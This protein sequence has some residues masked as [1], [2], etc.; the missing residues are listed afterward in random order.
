ME[1]CTVD[2]FEE[3]GKNMTAVKIDEDVFIFD[4]G[5]YIPGIVELQEEDQK[6]EYTVQ[7]LRRVKA[8]PDDRVLD[9]LGWRDKVRAII[10]SH[11]HLDHVGGLPYL[12]E[13]YPNVPIYGTPFT[14]KFLELF[15][16]DEK[17]ESKN[18]MHVIKPDSTIILNGKSGSYKV[19]F[20]NTTHSTIQCV[21][22]ALH[23]RD[24]IF[25]YALDLK[26][27]NHPTMGRPPNYNKMRELGKKGVKVLVLDALYSSTEK[28]PGSETVAKH[29]LE[30]AFSRATDKKAAI[31]ITTFSSHVERLNN[32]VEFARKTKREIIFLGRSLAKYMEAATA[33]GMCPFKNHV[34]VVKYRKQINSFLSRIE[35][36]RGRYLV[37]CTGH[38]AEENS[39]LDRITKGET[40][41]N[42]KPGDNL[43]FSSSV[44]P[45]PINI[46]ARAKMDAKLRKKGVKLQVDVHVHGHG[47][48]DDMRELIKMTKPEQ[49]I[50]AHGTLEQEAP[51]I[52]LAKEFGYRFG[53]TSHLTS[54]GKLFKF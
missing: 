23:T 46:S 36:A 45:V 33:V 28:R 5:L 6:Q 40:P 27:D 13:R 14:M 18:P 37:V 38:Q 48:R 30:E 24:G 44:I 32:I 17:I 12:L 2:G 1:V 26:F 31:F 54:N 25:F 3:V 21:F 47:S 49:I 10:I 15:L 22:L 41:F 52:E 50:P 39:I 9:A 51:L 43:I 35:K 8:I 34:K 20:I 4:A 29:M 19:D 16:R 53:E 11:A 7:K 42:F